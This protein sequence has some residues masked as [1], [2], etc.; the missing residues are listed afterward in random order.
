VLVVGAVEPSSAG[1]VIGREAERLRRLVEDLLDLARLGRPGSSVRAEPVDLAG[2]A[3]EVTLSY[4]DR[5]RVFDEGIGS[6]EDLGVGDV[7][8]FVSE[9]LADGSLVARAIRCVM[10]APGG[11]G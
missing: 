11:A 1:E 4:D 9:E 5:T 3:R 6:V 7:A 2:A 8:V 10:P